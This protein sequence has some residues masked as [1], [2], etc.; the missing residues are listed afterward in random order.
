MYTSL[1]YL[2]IGARI[3][4]LTSQR[5]INRDVTWAVIRYRITKGTPNL[6]INGNQSVTLFLVHHPN[7]RWNNSRWVFNFY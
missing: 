5:K 6:N 2:R 4:D 1:S 3:N 7:Q